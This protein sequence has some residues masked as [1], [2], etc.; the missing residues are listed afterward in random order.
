[1]L[2]LLHAASGALSLSLD[3]NWAYTLSVDG[4]PWLSSGPTRLHNVSL[5]KLSSSEGSGQDVLGAYAEHQLDYAC[6]PGS[7]DVCFS[8]LIRDYASA[9]PH[10]P[11]VVFLQRHVCER[12]GTAVSSD[13]G[14]AKEAVLSAFPSFAVGSDEPELGYMV[15]YDQMV[16]GMEDGTRYGRWA[17]GEGVV[18][19]TM[20]GPTVIFDAAQKHALVLSPWTNVM[21]G[22]SVQAAPATSGDDAFLEFGL[23]GSITCTRRDSN[24]LSPAPASRGLLIGSLIAR[25]SLKVHPGGL[26]VCIGGVSRRGRQRRRARIEFTKELS[27]VYVV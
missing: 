18:G 8:T 12:N 20:G 14:G 27:M 24:S 25:A 11:L 26:R 21:A 4:Q 10:T 7:A 3:K 22:S 19:G 23:L 2:S 13:V 17:A 9:D 15:Y 6:A 1:M 5:A 16:G